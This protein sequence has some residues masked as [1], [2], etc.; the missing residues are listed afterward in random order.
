MIWNYKLITLF[1]DT[2]NI[3]RNYYFFIEYKFEE[4]LIFDKLTLN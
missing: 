3:F 2:R 4:K 1:N